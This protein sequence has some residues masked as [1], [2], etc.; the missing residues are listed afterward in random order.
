MK[1]TTKKKTQG[2]GGRGTGK[3]KATRVHFPLLPRFL[4]EV[5]ES[6][7]VQVHGLN[8]QQNL[9]FAFVAFALIAAII[10]RKKIIR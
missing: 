1:T 8:L 2:R 3:A 5:V 6:K 4:Q 10:R 7:A 9:A